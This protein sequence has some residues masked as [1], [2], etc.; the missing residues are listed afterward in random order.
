MSHKTAKC[1]EGCRHLK[2]SG[3]CT[4]YLICEEWRAWFRKEWERIQK[5]AGVYKEKKEAEVPK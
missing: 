4:H 1:C 2:A 3:A 5:A